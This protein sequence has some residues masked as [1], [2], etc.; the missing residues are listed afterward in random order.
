MMVHL[1]LFFTAKRYDMVN[2]RRG[3]WN[4][5]A[6]LVFEIVINVEYILL[7]IGLASSA[8][9]SKAVLGS[10]RKRRGETYLLSW[11]IL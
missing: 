10:S 11:Y 6:Q 3:G 5:G 1:F 7:F 2:S 9:A 4:R 8:F